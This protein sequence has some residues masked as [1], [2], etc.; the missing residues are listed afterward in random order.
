M[1]LP[2]ELMCVQSLQ[3]FQ[4][5]PSPGSLGLMMGHLFKPLQAEEMAP[6]SEF[7][8]SGK[9]YFISFV[10][11]SPLSLCPLFLGFI[12]VRFW[13]SGVDL[14]FSFFF[15]LLLSISL[16]FYSTLGMISSKL[17]LSFLFHYNFSFQEF[18]FVP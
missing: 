12:I 3:W 13:T 14:I 17:T 8:G 18:F 10:I 6:T 5:P 1:W 9:L 4:G 15:L 11:F 7:F 16:F 2:E